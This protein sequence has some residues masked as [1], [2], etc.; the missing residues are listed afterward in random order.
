MTG[1]LAVEGWPQVAGGSTE[2]KKSTLGVGSETM[3]T[4]V[5]HDDPSTSYLLQRVLDTRGHEPLVCACP[6]EAFARHAA[7]PYPLIIADVGGEDGRGQALCRHIR[8]LPD[9]DR[10]VLLGVTGY[11]ERDELRAVLDAGATDYLSTPLEPAQL[12]TRLTI[13]ERLVEERDAAWGERERN[14]RIAA[15]LPGMTMQWHLRTC[16]RLE[17]LHASSG[18]VT[19]LAVPPEQVLGDG[20]ALVRLIHPL[21]RRS[22]LRSLAAADMDWSWEGRLVGTTPTRWVRGVGRAASH[23]SS[24][25]AWDVHLSD[26]SDRK[27]IERHGQAFDACML[28]F[29]D[30]LVSNERALLTLLRE[31]LECRRAV[32]VPATGRSLAVGD[33][34]PRDREL[35]Q[36]AA[37]AG[38]NALPHPASGACWIGTVDLEDGGV[39]RL[40]VFVDDCSRHPTVPERSLLDLVRG[41]VRMEERRAS[42]RAALSRGEQ[43]FDALLDHSPLGIAV[44]RADGQLERVSDTLRSILGRA[45]L[46]DSVEA[47]DLLPRPLGDPL[48]EALAGRGTTG[49]ADL[50]EDHDVPVDVIA[51]RIPG[52]PPRAACFVRDATE[53]HDLRAKLR[54]ADHLASL[55]MIAAAVAHDLKTPL[56][57]IGTNLDHAVRHAPPGE[58]AQLVQETREGVSKL[59][60]IIAPLN[61][62]SRTSVEDDGPVDVQEVMDA[63]AVLATYQ[64]RDRAI[65]E[66]RFDDVPAVRADRSRLGQVF[67]NLLVNAAQA[68]PPGAKDAHHIVVSTWTA[69]DGWATI[70]VSDTGC[71]IALTDLPRIWEPFFSTKGDSGGHGLGLHVCRTIIREAGGEID[72][73][74]TV[75]TGT[76][77][78]VRLPPCDATPVKPQ[79]AQT[80]AVAGKRC[81]VLVIDDDPLLGRCI[82]RTL[83]EHDVRVCSSGHEALRHLATTPYDVVLCDLVMP[84]P[85]GIDL[86]E[87]LRAR[88]P[89]QARR[90]VFVTGGAST[91]REETFLADRTTP[92]LEKPFAE[93]RLRSLV[94]EVADGAYDLVTG[95]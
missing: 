65:L 46:P 81:R 87:Q 48:R 59:A 53:R 91:S 16:G 3:R 35:F 63:Y 40:I 21:D 75:G 94:Y 17:V 19:L 14:Q 77:F 56:A 45:G 25:T 64:V 42:A 33:A 52:T 72:V 24:R 26:I 92:V 23:T 83:A 80:V 82:G 61:D 90:V 88:D 76:T 34:H 39:A 58:L 38:W 69:E 78:T 8:G 93:D 95:G 29:G 55:G 1:S 89:R 4:L 2:G 60:G 36:T 84:D 44:A 18:C 71:G 66:R 43:L 32:L 70:E 30:D 28:E 67:L 49:D 15:S 47:I 11:L 85:H 9:G 31:A 79:A 27:A 13:A 62:Y 5:V 50:G 7:E 86:Y 57:Y 20:F 54:R 12:M 51:F 6:V 68:I 22:F 74:S 73:H 41:A 37:E 10:P